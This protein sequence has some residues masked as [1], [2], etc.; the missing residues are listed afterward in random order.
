MGPT[1]VVDAINKGIV[2]AIAHGQPVAAE[3]DDAN[4]MVVVDFRYRY[5]ENI[6]EL[7]RQPA[8]A[9]DNDHDDQHFNDLAGTEREE[10]KELPGREKFSRMLIN[11]KTYFE[12]SIIS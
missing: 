10:I 11:E 4:E 12:Y 7:Q 5:I 9:K 2:T 8:K 3:P 1:Y 6:I